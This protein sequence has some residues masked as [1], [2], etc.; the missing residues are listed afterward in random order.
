MRHTVWAQFATDYIRKPNASFPK[1]NNNDHL[2]K[3]NKSH[4][5]HTATQEACNFASTQPRASGNFSQ[6]ITIIPI[7]P[8]TQVQ[9][10]QVE[11]KNIV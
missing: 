6:A 4:S 1:N 10:H 11:R 7:P 8:S 2:K 9:F 3:P 5:D